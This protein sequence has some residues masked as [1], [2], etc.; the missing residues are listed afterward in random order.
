MH[1]ATL[2]SCDITKQSVCGWQFIRSPMRVEHSGY[3]G[4]KEL[5]HTHQIFRTGASSQMQM[6]AIVHL[7]THTHTHIC[8]CVCVCVCVSIS[9]S[10]SYS[11]YHIKTRIDKTQ[12]NRKCSL[13]GDRDETI[14]HIISECSKLAQ[15]EYKT[16]HDWV[17]K[18][19]HWEEENQQ[20]CRLCCPGWPQNNT[21][22]MSKEA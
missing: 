19:I 10:L 14:N 2:K 16:W 18:V 22:R 15:M 7:G 9:I 4:N 6:C 3:R 20:N 17:F 8:V 12:Q 21:E 13:C 5:L 1:L 11:L